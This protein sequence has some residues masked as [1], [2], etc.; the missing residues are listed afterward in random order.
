MIDKNPQEKT[1]EQLY[2]DSEKLYQALHNVKSKTLTSSNNSFTWLDGKAES[3]TVNDFE[4]EEEDIDGLLSASFTHT[5]VVE[6]A[7]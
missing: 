5:C 6:R 2:S 3:I 1:Y 4:E 7:E